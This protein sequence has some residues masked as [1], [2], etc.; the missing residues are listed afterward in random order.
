[1]TFVS[2]GSEGS[3]VGTPP[4]VCPM[5]VPE[6]GR[7]PSSPGCTPPPLEPPEPPEPLV[8]ELDGLDEEQAPQAQKKRR[9]TPNGK[10]NRAI[11]VVLLV[12]VAAKGDSGQA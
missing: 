8:A 9:A 3:F 7:P 12:E 10:H 2:V 11:N 5:G 4:S 6:P 1:M